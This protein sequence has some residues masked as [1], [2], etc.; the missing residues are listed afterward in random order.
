MIRQSSE[1]F[2]EEITRLKNSGVIRRRGGRVAE[3]I[4]RL[5]TTKPD[6]FNLILL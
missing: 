2:A 5:K 1:R 6:R 4:M 3:K